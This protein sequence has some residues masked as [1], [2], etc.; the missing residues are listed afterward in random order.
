MLPFANSR[1]ILG[2]WGNWR[3]TK[4]N[5]CY[6]SRGLLPRYSCYGVY[7]IASY[8]S[9]FLLIWLGLSPPLLAFILHSSW[10]SSQ[11]EVH[12]QIQSILTLFIHWPI[13]WHLLKGQN[14]LIHQDFSWVDWFF[15][16]FLGIIGSICNSWC[17]PYWNCGVKTE[18]KG[19]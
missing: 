6:I 13:C 15:P 9:A 1:T 10:N 19:F 5:S 2:A 4:A 18:R 14:Q 7:V 11:F 3:R 12:L 17:N 16:E 8:P